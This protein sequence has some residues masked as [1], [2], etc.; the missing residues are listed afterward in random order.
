[1]ESLGLL[2]C[3]WIFSSCSEQGLLLLI[4]FSNESALRNRWSKY[5]SFSFS[6]RPSNECSGLISYRIDWFE[7][8]A[9]QGTLKES[10]PAPQFGNINSL[11]L[12]LPYGATLELLNVFCLF[13]RAESDFPLWSII[14]V[15]SIHRLPTPFLDFHYHLF[16][17]FT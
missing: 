6:I 5:W 15:I 1:M 2:C 8:L 16:S 3:M 7:L 12:N 10:S 17:I 4:V 9:I 11:T 13:L 14:T